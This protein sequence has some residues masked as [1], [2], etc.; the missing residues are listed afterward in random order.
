[1]IAMA[2]MLPALIPMVFG[3]AFRSAVL[4][5][6][7]TLF[8]SLFKGAQQVLGGGAAALGSP[9]LGSK[10]N[11]SAL[12][13]TVILLY[14]LVPRLGIVGAALSTAAAYLVELAVVIY[15]LHCTHLISPLNLFRVRANDIIPERRWMN[16]VRGSEPL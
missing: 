13:I 8:A 14:L 12:G 4:P 5:A 10:A 1:M 7:I 3:A 9:M 6:E 16:L 11:L 2:V 15:G